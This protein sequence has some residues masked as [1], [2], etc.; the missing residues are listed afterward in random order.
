MYHKQ[1]SVFE[2]LNSKEGLLMRGTMLRFSLLIVAV[3]FIGGCGGVPILNVTDSGV[4]T[5]TGKEATLDQVTK[6]ILDAATASRPPWLMKVIKPGHILAKLQNR[7][8]TAAVDI[9]YTTKAY[10]IMYKNSTNLKFNPEGPTIHGNYNKWIQNL[11][12][13]IKARLNTL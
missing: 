9:Q 4:S 8:H 11:D 7:R 12:L 2:N 1:F 13:A 6:A 3:V 10:S 5:A